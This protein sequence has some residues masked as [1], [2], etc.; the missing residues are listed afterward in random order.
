MSSK[1]NVEL[2]VG[3]F[4]FVGL[5][6]LAYLIIRLGS[7]DKLTAGGYEIVISY[8]FT[9]GVIEGAP[10]RVAGVEAGRVKKL[11]LTPDQETKVDV[12]VA[13]E[14]SVQLRRN[15]I[16]LIN[17]LGIMG[18]KYIEILPQDADSEI[19][20]PG[21][22]IIGEEPTSIADL[23]RKAKEFAGSLESVFKDGEKGSKLS[24]IMDNV[25]LM[26]GEK[27]RENFSA[28]LVNLN[29]FSG[30]MNTFGTDIE[31]LSQEKAFSETVHNFHAAS[32]SLNE[33]LSQIRSGKGTLGKLLYD[34]EVHDNLKTLIQDLMKNPSKL[35]RPSPDKE[36]GKGSFLFP[37]KDK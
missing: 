29:E 8:K 17:S 7:Y 28:T 21:D 20:K 15:S 3:L 34:T 13:I 33:V 23:T 30:K 35:F 5:A 32:Q 12:V 22:R 36:H 14:K 27:N 26:T 31:T 11:I 6:T 37:K 18:E 19:L 4:L 2:W 16:V 25:I 10:V 9:N 1:K 24:Q